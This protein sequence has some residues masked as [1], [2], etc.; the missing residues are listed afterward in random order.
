MASASSSALCVDRVIEGKSQACMVYE[1]SGEDVVDK[2]IVFRG[3]AYSI[4]SDDEMPPRVRALCSGTMHALDTVGDGACAL[5]A[6]FGR[7]T[8]GN[9]YLADAREF[10]ARLLRP[11][12]DE[13]LERGAPPICVVG[14]KNTLWHEFQLRSSQQV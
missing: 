1:L 11:S 14:V 4:I 10:A 8:A 3:S 12:P 7:P 6:V 5:H 13:L 2:R 9:L